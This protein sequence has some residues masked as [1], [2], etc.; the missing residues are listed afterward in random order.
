[1]V[2]VLFADQRLDSKSGSIIPAFALTDTTTAQFA[3]Q[4]YALFGQA[5]YSISENLDL[6][7]GLRLELNDRSMNRQHPGAPA[8]I[9][10]RDTFEAA[11]PRP[12]SFIM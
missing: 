12:E 9:N 5:T 1:V 4:T 6:I 8:D 11:L 7:G 3:N 10:L 2:G